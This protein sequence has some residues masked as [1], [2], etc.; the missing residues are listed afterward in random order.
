VLPDVG[1]SDRPGARLGVVGLRSGMLDMESARFFVGLY[2][3]IVISS[4]P[5]SLLRVDLGRRLPARSSVPPRSKAFAGEFSLLKGEPSRE[6][7]GIAEGL[8]GAGVLGVVARF[9]S[10]ILDS[11]VLDSEVLDCDGV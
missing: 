1:R 5:S 7:A 2:A 3:L 11:A 10:E 9:G 6:G 8:R 4:L